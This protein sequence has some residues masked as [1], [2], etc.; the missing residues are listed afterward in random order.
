MFKNDATQLKSIH[1]RFI[2]HVYPGETLDI[3]VWRDGQNSYIYE[4]EVRERK[5]KAVVGVVEGR[6]AAKL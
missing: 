1:A 3:S 2:G 6:P 4:A 5:T